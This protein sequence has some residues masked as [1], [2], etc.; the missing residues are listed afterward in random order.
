MSR[1][2]LKALQLLAFGYAIGAIPLIEKK[3]PR[4]ITDRDREKIAAA[5]A[6]RDRKS[7]KLAKQTGVQKP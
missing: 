3:G 4:E 5:Q 2:S 7:A 6:K 1:I